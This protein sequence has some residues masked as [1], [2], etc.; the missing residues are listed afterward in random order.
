MTG[1][2]TDRHNH[3]ITQILQRNV[4]K[5]FQKS[6]KTRHDK[7]DAPFLCFIAQPFMSYHIVGHLE[8][9]SCRQG[10]RLLPT[11]EPMWCERADSKGTNCSWTILWCLDVCGACACALKARSWALFCNARRRCLRRICH[12]MLALP[13]VIGSALNVFKPSTCADVFITVYLYNSFALSS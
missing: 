5:L 9:S 12:N 3:T 4:Y 10:W 8:D 11:K 7:K 1:G 13:E 2:I 6:A